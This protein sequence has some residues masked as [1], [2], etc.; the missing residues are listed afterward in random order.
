MTCLD[1]AIGNLTLGNV[2]KRRYLKR[3]CSLEGRTL[4]DN[5]F[6]KSDLVLLPEG[7]DPVP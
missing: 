1:I 2:L 7:G 3:Y 6:G 5:A 4:S